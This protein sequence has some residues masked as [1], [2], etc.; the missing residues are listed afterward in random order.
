VKALFALAL[1]PPVH[2]SSGSRL[3]IAAVRFIQVKFL[4]TQTR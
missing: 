2:F 4:F 1:Y 3:A